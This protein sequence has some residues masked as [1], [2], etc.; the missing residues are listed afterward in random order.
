MS[1]NPG[2]SHFGRVVFY[3][4]TAAVGGFLFGFD[5]AVI[6]G[7]V[8]AL[9]D[10]FGSGSVGTGFSVASMLLGCAAGSLLAGTLADKAGRK[11]VMLASAL[12]F[13]ASAL[14]SGWATDSGAFIVFRLLGEMFA[15]RIRG[16]AMA[17]ATFVLWIANFAI[18]MTFPPLLAGI[19]LGGS[20]ALY[21]GFAALSFFV[22]LRHV[23]ETRGRPLENPA[24]GP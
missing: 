3:S 13:L 12:A 17:L 16:S 19:G 2:S 11:P 9:Q 4:A 15:N 5:S 18:T 14:G 24:A 8:G 23:P 22:V 6:N 1:A 20:Y 21:G 10:A 7:T